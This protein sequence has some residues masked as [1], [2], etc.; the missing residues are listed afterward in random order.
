VSGIRASDNF[1]DLGGHSLMIMRAVARVEA[2]T[3]VRLSP[4]G[5]VFQ[6]LAQIAA[7][8]DAGST[9]PMQVLVEPAAEPNG[10]LQRMA[11]LFSRPGR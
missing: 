4:R 9:Q 6:T 11:R 3:G 5:F 7:E 1:L 8:I 2:L 10:L